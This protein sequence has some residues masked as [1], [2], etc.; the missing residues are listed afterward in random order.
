MPFGNGSIRQASPEFF[1]QA[2]LGEL[3]QLGDCLERGSSDSFPFFGF[4]QVLS[5]WVCHLNRVV[6][7]QAG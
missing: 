7:I 1:D 5:V 3:R 6:V 4:L 2:L